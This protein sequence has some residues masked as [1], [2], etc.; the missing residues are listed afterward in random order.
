MERANLYNINIVDQY[1][2]KISDIIPNGCNCVSMY[3]KTIDKKIHHNFLTNYLSCLYP[4]LDECDDIKNIIN[5][6]S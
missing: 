4:K 6:L 1:K 2:Q 5:Q 3:Q